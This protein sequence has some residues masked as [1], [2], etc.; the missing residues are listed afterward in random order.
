M[1]G[2]DL[3]FLDRYANLPAWLDRLLIP[4]RHLYHQGFY[5]PEGVLSTIPAAASTLLGAVTG[6]WIRSTRPISRKAHGLLLASGLCLASGLLWSQ[7]F[8]LNKPLWTSSFVLWTGGTSLF[9]LWFFF[10]LVDVR[11][12]MQQWIYPAVVFGTNALTAYIFSEFLAKLLNFIKLPSGMPLQHWLFK[13]LAS[14]IPNPQLA[15]L[16][17]AVLFAGVCFLPAWILYRKH[18][19]LKV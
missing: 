1:P 7:W 8:P 19:F 2:R 5:D 14:S 16:A 17:Y 12:R 3:L 6:M 13:P 18:I 9:A 10:W 4:A 11:Q 15:A